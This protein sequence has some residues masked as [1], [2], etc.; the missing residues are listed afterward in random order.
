M[1]KVL[2]LT[3]TYPLSSSDSQPRFVEYLC[4]KL[5]TY[6][7]VTILTPSIKG[8]RGTLSEDVCVK[9]FRYFWAHFERL[10]GGDGILENLKSSKWL[11]LLIPFFLMA[12]FFHVVIALKGHRFQAIHAH[13]IIPQGLVAVIACLFVKNAPPILLTSHGGD[14]FALNGKLISAIKKFVLRRV[15]HITVVSSAM[16]DRCTREFGV[17][18]ERISVMPMGVDL[19]GSFVPLDIKQPR[20]IVFVGRLAEKKD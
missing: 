1:Q 18:P 3:S 14:L 11:F 10:C 2:V 15:A 19:K 8:D 9:R 7:D 4:K 13:W 17:S 5:A 20:Q 6:C 12:Q 16:K